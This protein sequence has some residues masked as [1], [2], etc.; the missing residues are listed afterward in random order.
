MIL[1]KSLN[2]IAL[3]LILLLVSC[4]SPKDIKI[5]G[6]TMGTTYEI[7][8]R[9]YNGKSD[10]LKNKIDSLFSDINNV[11]S[12]YILNSEISLINDSST[13][14]ISISDELN[15]VL[16]K[17]LFYC[18]L[19]SGSY[20]ITIAP[21]VEE[22][23]F[24]KSKTQLIP[25]EES[26]LNLLNNIGYDKIDVKNNKLYRKNKSI[27]IDLN[28]I[29]KGYAVDE[30]FSL[31]K[32]EGYNDFLIE[33]GGEISSS[34]HESDGWI[35]GIQNPTQN[36]IVKKINLTN[37][38][39]ATSGTYNNYF[40]KNGK[41]FSHIINPQTGYPYDYS[42]VSATIITNKC[43]DADAYATMAMTMKVDKFLNIVNSKKNVECYLIVLNEYGDFIYY[44]SNN[45]KDFIY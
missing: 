34:I 44:E 17:S 12:T 10:I 6:Y 41:F 8:L 19:S 15:Y 1:A 42:I 33:I 13:D 38:S 27:S 18:E 14:V 39:M 7:T 40:E 25:S 4:N 30:V 31:I 45:F 24:G 3:T 35:V 20:D 36:G 43:I 11:F 2:S 28:S 5:N 29:A 23:G 37:Q 16:E 22:W 21:L 26:I 9:N 32:K